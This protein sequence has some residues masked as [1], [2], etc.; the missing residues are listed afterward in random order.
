MKLGKDRKG[1]GGKG[2]AGKETTHTAFLTNRTLLILSPHN[3]QLNATL[4]N[5]QMARTH[6]PI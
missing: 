1:E 6:T 2:V 5:Y 3:I 4:N